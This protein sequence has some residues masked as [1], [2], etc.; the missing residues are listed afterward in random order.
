M[1]SNSNDDNSSSNSNKKVHTRSQYGRF[2]IAPHWIKCVHYT[3]T[4]NAC[5]MRWCKGKW[6]CFFLPSR[7]SPIDVHFFLLSLPF[8]FSFQFIYCTRT[9]RNISIYCWRNSRFFMSFVVV[10]V[11]NSFCLQKI[12]AKLTR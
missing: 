5:D 4:P 6:I 2:I 7:S 10:V 12:E 1:N 8:F 3:E 9:T 11:Q